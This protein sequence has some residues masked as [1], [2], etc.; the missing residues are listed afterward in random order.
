[1]SFKE[2]YKVFQKTNLNELP[3]VDETIFMGVLFREQIKGNEKSADPISL[4]KD[5][6]R[7]ISV[8]ENERMFVVLKKMTSEGVA[9]IPVINDEGVLL[10]I[11][12]SSQLWNEFAEKSGLMGSGAW[13]VVSMKKNDYHLSEIAQIAEST[14]MIIVMHFVHFHHGVDLIDVHLKFDHEN[15]IG[16]VQ[17][18]QRYKYNVTDVIQPKKFSDDWEDKFDELMRYFS[19]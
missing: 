5:Q 1:M 7:L 4:L 14:G 10:G 12:F 9:S 13:I 2:T 18:L 6:F 3:V 17:S 11:I 15:V 16:L 8:E 19:T